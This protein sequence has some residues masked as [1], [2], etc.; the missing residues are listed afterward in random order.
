MEVRAEL[1]ALWLVTAHPQAAAGDPEQKLLPWK[2]AFAAH[3]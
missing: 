2:G 1:G 3:L